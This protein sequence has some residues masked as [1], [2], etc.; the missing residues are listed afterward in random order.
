MADQT[1]DGRL[2][3]TLVSLAAIIVIVAGIAA[4]QSIIVHL[5]VALFLSVISYGVYSRLA[6][7]G[8][9]SPLAMILVI[10]LVI[11]LLV[12]LI[13]LVKTTIDQFG[14]TLMQ[15]QDRFSAWQADL[16]AWLNELGVPLQDQTLDQYL[17]LNR[18]VQLFTSLLNTLG[19]TLSSASLVI[20]MVIFILMEAAQFTRKLRSAFRDPE[21][22]LDFIDNFNDA[23]ER[24]FS[25]KT[26]INVAS[27]IFIAIWTAVFGVQFAL[28]WGMLTFLLSY[29][30]YFGT[31]IAAVP[32]ILIA[33]LTAS[34]LTAAIVALGFL[35]MGILL[36]NYLEPRIFGQGMGLSILVVFVS[37]LFWGW[38]LGLVGMIFTVPLTVALKLGLE[39]SPR[40]RWIALLLADRPPSA[41]T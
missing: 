23:I 17:D 2:A 27:G 16:K 21:P 19:S 22:I 24:Y 15:Y 9:P 40:T 35:V 4:A 6:R 8:V 34:W 20:A 33:G 29:I 37:M 25:I 32:P 36:G 3:Y 30:P 39:S 31:V 28:L 10:L 12:S 1:R 14:S 41:K 11:G 26:L 38:I 5:M 18:G 13:F 7:W